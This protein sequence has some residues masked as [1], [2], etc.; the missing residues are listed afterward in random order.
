VHFIEVKTYRRKGHAEHDDQHYVPTGELD[1]WATEND[2]VDRYVH[3]LLSGD[4]VAASDL[5]EIDARVRDEVDRA[6]DACANEALPEAE[7]AL[8]GVYV[9]PPAADKLWFK[10]L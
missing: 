4:L 9:E 3:R 1:R 6:T 5:K 2:P 8:P 7:S 10:A